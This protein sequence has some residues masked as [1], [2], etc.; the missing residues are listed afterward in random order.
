MSLMQKEFYTSRLEHF[1]SGETTR[2]TQT[3]SFGS[4]AKPDSSKMD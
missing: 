1:D 4:L 3:H 2:H